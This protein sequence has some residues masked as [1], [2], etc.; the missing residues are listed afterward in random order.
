LASKQ[1]KR[2]GDMIAGTIVVRER[3][4]RVPVT[5]GASRAAAT[6]SAAAAIHTLL[7]DDEFAV[8]SRFIDRRTQLD[9][10]RRSQLTT[11]LV[12]RFRSR[13]PQIEGSES[14]FLVALFEH[15]RA[16]RTRGVAA[17]S[18]TGAAREQHSLVAAGTERWAKFASR[19]AEVQEIGIANL[20]ESEVSKFVAQYREMATDLA[21]L[22]TASRGARSMPYSR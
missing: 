14:A 17:R 6:T 22:Q 18:D 8:L 21:R 3:V 19:L 5:A 4:A 2:I 11:Q 1:G 12:Q 16:A 13:A 10:A 9:G 20:P 15:E 7:T